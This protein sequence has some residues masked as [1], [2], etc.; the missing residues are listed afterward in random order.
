MNR[1]ELE[2]SSSKEFILQGNQD[3]YVETSKIIKKLRK[4][5]IYQ[6]HKIKKINEENENLYSILK[7]FDKYITSSI[8]KLKVI[9]K[10]DKFEFF[11]VPLPTKSEKVKIEQVPM[12]HEI[13]Y[14]DIKDEQLQEKSKMKYFEIEFK[15]DDKNAIT[16]EKGK[17]EE[18]V[19]KLSNK[20]IKICKEITKS[21]YKERKKKYKKVYK[22]WKNIRESAE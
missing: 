10:K 13:I 21:Q 6:R 16:I 14:E 3:F 18:D 17:S 11:F 20:I 9:N 19:L 12:S 4:K 8:K 1:F 5:I 7:D 15:N 2:N 22:I